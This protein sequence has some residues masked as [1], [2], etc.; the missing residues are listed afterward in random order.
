MTDSVLV[1]GEVASSI[2]ARILK[3]KDL[4]FKILIDKGLR[5]DDSRRQERR[6]AAG[7]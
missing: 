4:G 3:L 6:S 7:A 1:A 2:A 5:G